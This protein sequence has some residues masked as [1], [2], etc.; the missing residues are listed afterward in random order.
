MLPSQ[1]SR[2]NNPEFDPLLLGAGWTAE[3]LKKPQVLLESTAGDSHPGSRH[4]KR[5][6]DEAKAGVYKS[7]GKPAVYTVTDI[8]DGVASGHA[9]MNYSLVSRDIIS[10]MVEIHARALPF[11]AM[12]TFSS[13]D[14]AIPAHLMAIARLNI[15]TIHF[16]GGSMMPGPGFSTAVK[17][18]ETIESVAKGD[19]SAQQSDFYKMNACSSCGACQYMGTAS[20]MQVLAEAL[21]LSLP[22][23]ALMP[24]WSSSIGHYADRAG[25]SILN[26]LDKNILPA[27][28]LSP[29]AFEN[30]IMVHA[31]VSGSTNALL[32]LPA[33]AGQAG[34]HVTPRD[35]DRIHKKIP[36]LAGLQMTGRW[37]TQI[38]WYAGGVPAIM[39]TL[40]DHLH[41]DAL[42]VTAKSVGDNLQDLEQ[43]GFFE[44]TALYLENFGIKPDE[45]IQALDSPYNANGGLTI[46]QGNLAPES[47]VV[48][49]AAVDPKMH[50]HVGP[51]R[52][53]DTEEDAIDAVLKERIVPGDVVIIRYE[54][55]KGSGMPEMFRATETIY[56]RPEL[57]ASIALVTDGRF[58]GATRG[59]AIG[60][61]TPEAAAG[62]PLALVEEG[63]LISIDIAAQTLDIVGFDNTRQDP[64]A[65]DRLL[66]ERRAAWK[67]FDKKPD[68]VLG[69]FTRMAGD[70]HDG[71]SM[72]GKQK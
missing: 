56:N 7:G 20:T 67:R 19:M 71:A 33:I 59:P 6:V 28:I 2:K 5:L 4:L 48:K 37:P 18:Y 29:H 12:V 57:R 69:L 17:C 36:V 25:G 47:A 41:L 49:H 60:H 58:S 65:V 26:L 51:A 39:R 27:D 35:F 9:G 16:S 15:P 68:G 11:D 61:V 50:R 31:A 22:G 24:A 34:I 64:A 63:D 42:T 53:F 54:G 66:Q 55:P 13:C 1:K 52:P 14:K 32:H 44:Q 62:G 10:A 21:G 8:C 3:D 23:N 46:L 40:K 38:L 45:V 70:T 72:L 30:A 43:N